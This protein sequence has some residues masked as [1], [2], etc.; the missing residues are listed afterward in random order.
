VEQFSQDHDLDCDCS[1][2]RTP[3]GGDP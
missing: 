2:N 3:S 1:H